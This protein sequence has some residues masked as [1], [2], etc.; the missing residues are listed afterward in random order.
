MFGDLALFC[1]K[2][3]MDLIQEFL[4]RYRREFDFY[5]QSARL[6]AQLLDADLQATGIRAMVTSRAKQPG[7]L[8]SKVRQRNITANY[9]TVDDIFADIVDLAGARV[10]LYFPAEREE[11]GKIIQSRFDVIEPPKLFPTGAAPSYSKRFSGYWATHYRTRIREASLPDSQKRYSDARIEIQVAS[12]LMHAWSEVEHDLVYKPLQGNLSD[13][14]YAILD[15]LNGLVLAGEIA[16]ERLQRAG[17]ARVAERGST[18]SNHYDLAAYLFDVAKRILATVPTEVGMGRV[19]VLFD[20]LKRLSIDTPEA[21][22]TYLGALSPDMEARPLAEQIIDQ[23]LAADSTRY[24]AYSEIRDERDRQ[25]SFQ[26]PNETQRSVE[27]HHA[28]GF[29]LS[30]WIAIERIIR[31]VAQTSGVED[32]PGVIPTGRLLARLDLLDEQ[33][34]SEFDRL[35]R[36]RNLLVHGVEVPRPE[37]VLDAGLALN[38]LIYR[39]TESA[40][41]AA[42][43]AARRAL[44]SLGDD[45]SPA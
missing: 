4:N 35:R 40:N 15:E 3:N 2:E 17:E 39:M 21:L 19:D 23:V 25:K 26:T 18:F 12:V 30:N 10:A 33:D 31:E 37:I 11:V 14:E 7:R 8:E 28:L 6:L 45:P 41:D 32:S 1:C 38:R 36:L 13:D 22:G 29:F 5:D 43:T 9:Q 44:T 42:R 24:A 16:L 20:F 34:R 27:Q